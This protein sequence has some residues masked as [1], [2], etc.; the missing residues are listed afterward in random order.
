MKKGLY[1]N[2]KE[3]FNG[4]RKQLTSA[5]QITSTIMEK[6]NGQTAENGVVPGTTSNV[7]PI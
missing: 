1:Q 3:Q 2:E 5:G 4:R 6:N 7:Q